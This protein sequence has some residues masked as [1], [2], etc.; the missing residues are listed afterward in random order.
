MFSFPSSQDDG[1]PLGEDPWPDI[2]ICLGYFFKPEEMRVARQ[3][4]PQSMNVCACVRALHRCVCHIQNICV[5]QLNVFNP[6]FFH[7]LLQLRHPF[8]VQTTTS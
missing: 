6:P 8:F 3:T 2:S 7:E 1:R 5:L 4:V